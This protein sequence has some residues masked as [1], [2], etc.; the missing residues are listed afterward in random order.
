MFDLAV[1]ETKKTQKL[2]PGF[3][4]S[5]V[6]HHPVKMIF[7]QSEQEKSLKEYLQKQLSEHH[8]IRELERTEIDS[9]LRCRPQYTD[10]SSGARIL[11]STRI[12]LFFYHEKDK[13]FVKM[14]NPEWFEDGRL[15][16]DF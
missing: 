1:K 6:G 13:N 14:K 7:N 16:I 8:I 15:F 9:F 11:L 5:L 12:S 2:V 10:L 4:F 3:T